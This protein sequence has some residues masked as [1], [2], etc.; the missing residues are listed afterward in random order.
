MINRLRRR[1]P[2]TDETLVPLLLFIGLAGLAWITPAQNDTW[3]HLRSG[4]E[5]WD[6]GSLLTTERFS[7]TA[8]GTEFHDYW[9][10][11]ELTFYA[12]FTWGGPILL[13]VFAGACAFAA[14][15]GS[16]RLM[17]GSWESRLVLLLFLI[18]AT[19]PEWS[20]RPQVVSLLFLVGAMYL[21]VN[22]RSQ[23]LPLLCIVWAN[24]HPQVIFALLIAGAAVIEAVIWSRDRI[25]RD[26]LVAVGCAAALMV[27]PYGWRYWQTLLNTVAISKAMQLQEYRTPL[28]WGSL[29]F[30]IAAAALI[31]LTLLKR[32]SLVGWRR[33]DRIFLISACALATASLGA[34][35]N[36]AFFA[37]VAAPVLSQ[38]AT[39]PHRI[40]RV[41]A[42][43]LGAAAY[44]MVLVA[45][46]LTTVGVRMCW[47]GGGTRLGWQPLSS[48]LVNAIQ[49]CQ[50]PM[51]N[52]LEDGGY[53][54]WALPSRRIFVDSRMHAYSLDLLRR[55]R[56]ADLHGD[57]RDLFRDYSISCAVVSRH[58]LIEQRLTQDNT[59]VSIFSDDDRTLFRRTAQ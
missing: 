55:S 3:W 33:T 21:F 5:M 27:S 13:T 20:V 57:Y 48:A 16:W 34:A 28:D 7:H 42:A 19:T 12:L 23:W 56:D 4:R 45:L 52:S 39:G 15:F 9:W 40:R 46:L 18:V 41:E 50:G 59:M 36:I 8:F 29:P 44:T 49:R 43:P 26:T 32:G 35:R 24:T 14:V 10:L 22:E 17:R 58:S 37:V 31:V 2:L 11:T 25:K 51:F 54:M 38:L 1:L 30:W 53:L 6:T 47:T